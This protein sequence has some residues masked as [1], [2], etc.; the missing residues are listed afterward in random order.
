MSRIIRNARKAKSLRERGQVLIVVTLAAFGIIAIIGLA[1]DVGIMFIDN[2]RLRRAVDAAALG[3]ALQVRENYTQEDL[4]K[5]ATEF[6]LLN[7]ITLDEDHPVHVDT[8]DTAPTLC[9]DVVNDIDVPRKLVRVSATADVRL[10]FLPVIGIDNVPIGATSVSETASLDVVLVIDRSQSMTFNALPTDQARDPHECNQGTSGNGFVGTCM[11][12]DTVKRAAVDFIDHLFYPYDRVAIVTF[13]KDPRVDLHLNADCP[14]EPC[15]EAEIRANISSVIKN[16]TVYEGEG[17]YSDPTGYPAR[18][19]WGDPNQPLDPEDLCKQTPTSY[20]DTN[21][22]SIPW[23]FIT[24]VS[25]QVIDPT[26]PNY[27]NPSGV[28]TTNIGGGMQLAGNEF[29]QP[30]IRQQALWVVI[31][32]T[33]GVPNNGYHVDSDGNIDRYFCPPDTYGN[34]IYCNSL[35]PWVRHLSTDAEYDAQ[36]YAYDMADFVGKPETSTSHGQ[37]ALIF[38][39]GL[40]SEVQNYGIQRTPPSSPVLYPGE[41][42]LKYAASSDVGRG[43]YYFA[44]SDTQLQEIFRKI[45]DNIAI[46]LTH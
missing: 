36:D 13:D 24:L 42:Y 1:L 31:L 9:H 22:N 37:G 12:F 17:D 29:A 25:P 18:C 15:T 16:L 32:L 11:P 39:I 43:E 30:P 5:A 8:C 10:A 45:A 20:T 6:L 26:D 19:Y 35:Q 3:A 23:N 46:R 28:G 40:G 14:S 4:D 21:G 44:P 41:E 38:A 33:D 27:F 34:E 2:A 7:D